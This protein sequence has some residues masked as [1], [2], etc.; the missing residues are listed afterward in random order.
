MTSLSV[1]RH[2]YW[3]FP[4]QSVPSIHR[5][6]RKLPCGGGR[7]P[8][9]PPLRTSNAPLRTRRLD[10]RKR[11]IDPSFFLLPPSSVCS[12]LSFYSAL[13]VRRYNAAAGKPLSGA[14]VQWYRSA[15]RLTLLHSLSL[16]G[17]PTCKCRPPSR[18]WGFSRNPDPMGDITILF[19]LEVKTW[20]EMDEIADV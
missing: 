17:V 3:S 4:R 11:P 15:R 5:P 16:F 13:S 10:Y 20:V 2:R 18:L 12:V 14:L 7:Y 9:P 6:E 8:A 1:R 19:H